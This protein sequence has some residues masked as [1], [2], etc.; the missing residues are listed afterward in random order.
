MI[1]AQFSNRLRLP[2]IG[3]PLFLISGPDLVVES[4]KAGIVGT[5]PSF[6]Q[7]TSEGYEQWLKE[8]RARLS[9]DCAPFGA[10]FSIHKTNARLDADLALTVKYQVP[11]LITSLGV[12]REV[13]DAVH[14]YGGVVFHDAIT[15]RHAKKA[16]EANVDGIIAVCGGAGGHAGTYN[17]LA[18]LA[19]L[20]PLMKGKTLILSGC[21]GDGNAVAAAIAAGA[22]MAYIGTRLIN[23]VESTALEATK[24]MILESD[25][26]DIV[27]TDQVDGIGANW[28]KK[29]VPG[30]GFRVSDL[31]TFNVSAE[32]ND[33]KRWKDI[34]SAGQGVGS[35]QDI[36][37][38]AALVDRL[39]AEFLAASARLGSI[40]CPA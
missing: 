29:T 18:F 39:E 20:R 9:D 2:V 6:N 10:Q 14:S 11:L 27:Y 7:R 30:S 17:P 8:I 3:A 28:L 1:P 16:L 24:Q 32:L 40:A 23:T 13:T 5:F 31:G 38:V 33:P 22:D 25:I 35:I 21:I 15:V 12:T 4:C 37:K 19:E 34:W 36:P 26:S